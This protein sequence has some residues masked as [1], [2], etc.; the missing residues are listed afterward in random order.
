MQPKKPSQLLRCVLG[1]PAR[2]SL[3]TLYLRH[4]SG[5]SHPTAEA[6]GSEGSG[7]ALFPP[8]WLD[9]SQ[10]ASSVPRK[11]AAW[12]RR[13]PRAPWEPRDGPMCRGKRGRSPGAGEVGAEDLTKGIRGCSKHKIQV[14][15]RW[16]Q[17]LKKHHQRVCRYCKRCTAVTRVQMC[18]IPHSWR[19][20]PD[21]VSV[22]GR[23]CFPHRKMW[24]SLLP[25][26][27]SLA[28]GQVPCRCR[29]VSR[30]VPRQGHGAGRA[31][32]RLLCWMSCQYLGV[33]NPGR[34]LSK[35]K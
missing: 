35:E 11:V 4:L 23:R 1:I 8:D 34:L 22:A 3:P 16:G 12:G 17:S 27:F 10:G 13:I 30:C 2:L 25:R 14:S 29:G 33:R 5:I 26:G 6:P 31:V 28:P 19:G 21:A 20:S 32:T 15:Q 7:Q 9:R 24:T 18:P